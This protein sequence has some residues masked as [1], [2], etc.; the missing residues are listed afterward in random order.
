MRKISAEAD[1]VSMDQAAVQ[2]ISLYGITSNY[3]NAVQQQQECRVAHAELTSFEFEFTDDDFNRICELMQF[4]V[5][6]RLGHDKRAMV[7]SRLGQQLRKLGIAS[8]NDYLDHIE[9]GTCGELATFINALTTNPT[10]FNREM[11]HFAIL[12]E[13]LQNGGVPED[14][15][16]WLVGCSTGEE[17]YSIAMVLASAPELRSRFGQIVASDIDPTVLEQAERGVY[18][19]ERVTNIPAADLKRFFLS[20]KGENAGFLKIRPQL[21]RLITFRQINLHDSSWPVR[22]P[23][24]V[25]FCRNVMNYFNAQTRRRTLERFGALLAPGG[26]LFLGHSENISGKDGVFQQLGQTVYMR[27]DR[28]IANHDDAWVQNGRAND[29]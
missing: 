19:A 12:R 21:R 20:G 3:W 5:G 16:I 10:N 22:A 18:P 26:L 13:F 6:I 17:A 7:Y 9:S 11:H 1:M 29:D 24:N 14:S 2:K 25:I 23:V 28:S 15:T 4:H 27:T 8:F